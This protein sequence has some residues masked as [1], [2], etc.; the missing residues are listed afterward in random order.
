[1][2]SNILQEYKNAKKIIMHQ[3]TQKYF[4]HLTMP[5]NIHHYYQNSTTTHAYTNISGKY[6]EKE[7]KKVRKMKKD[8]K[9]SVIS[10]W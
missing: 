5:T 10:R 9:M 8:R 1:M 3:H 7:R 4:R 6:R 2:I